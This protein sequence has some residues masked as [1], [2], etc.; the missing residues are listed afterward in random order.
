[1]TKT[2]RRQAICAE[3]VRLLGEEREKSGLSRKKVAQLAGLSQSTVSRLENYHENP[4]L[5]SILRVA[6]VLSINLGEVLAK[7]IRNVDRKTVS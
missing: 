3:L 2:E 1:M 6:D 5:D 7:A 4:T